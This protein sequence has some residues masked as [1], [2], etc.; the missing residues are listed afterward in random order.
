MAW[1]RILPALGLLASSPPSS[2]ARRAGQSLFP[3]ACYIISSSHGGLFTEVDSCLPA[4][5]ICA[6]W[7][8]SAHLYPKSI[9]TSAWPLQ[10]PAD[11]EERPVRSPLTIV[12]PP[13]NGRKGKGKQALEP[14]FARAILKKIKQSPKKVNLVARL[15]R[16]MRAQDALLQL[17]VNVKRAA[18]TVTEV[19]RSA[20]ANA[21]FNHAMDG[22]RLIIA[23]A[24][25]G[26]GKY[27]KR[28]RP[29]GKGK[30]GIMHHP[31][32]RLTVIVKELTPE[33][34]AELARIRTM[35]FRER[36]RYKSKLVPHRL[37]EST[38][39]WH[40][41]P[42]AAAPSIISHETA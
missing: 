10:N 38:W 4:R 7:I 24:F 9:S 28:I 17:A 41:K 19:I 33:Q 3:R 27:L 11:A 30:H 35:H 8:P 21:T 37:I 42:R 5:G 31:S 18:K 36:A 23:E 26:K 22:D 1:R 16:G 20:C 39:H 6:L 34:E 2:S 15:V 29:H 13:V 25:V 14:K 32:C 40:K 12:P